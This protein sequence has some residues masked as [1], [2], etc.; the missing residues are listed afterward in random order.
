MWHVCNVK[1]GAMRAQWC[2]VADMVRF[3]K[4]GTVKWNS[5]PREVLVRYEMGKM[6]RN[7]VTRNV[8]WYGII[9]EMAFDVE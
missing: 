1:W 6:V 7:G 4:H 5:V 9:P 3:F 8:V 2:N